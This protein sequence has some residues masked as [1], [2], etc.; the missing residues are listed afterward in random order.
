MAQ[1]EIPNPDEPKSKPSMKSVFLI[2]I[3]LAIVGAV[4][5]YLTGLIP[6][7]STDTQNAP[8]IKSSSDSTA[9]TSDEHGNGEKAAPEV[10][11]NQLQSAHHGT[12]LVITLDP[13][14]TNIAM[15]SNVWVRFEAVVKAKEPLEEDMPIQIHQDFLAFFHTM[16][17]SEL[18]GAS[19][20]IDLKAELLSRA[21][22]RTGGKIAAIYV[23]TF[24]FE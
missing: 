10:A 9:K 14:V 21:N 8:Q 15:P 17:L 4:C 24:I 3:T 1:K 20:F 5:G 19:A 18:S 6:L 22:T 13:I 23:K 2:A 11:S 16:R 12:S 7:S